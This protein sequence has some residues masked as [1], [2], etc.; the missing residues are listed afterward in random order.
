MKRNTVIKA[1]SALF[2]CLSGSGAAWA[3]AKGMQYISLEPLAEPAMLEKA[4]GSL[5]DDTKGKL[6]QGVKTVFIP[7]Y[8]VQFRV[9]S[10]GTFMKK[11]LLGSGEMSV[12]SLVRWSNPDPAVM[13]QVVDA[14]YADFVEQLKGAGFEVVPADKLVAMDEYKAIKP[15]AT[16]K[17]LNTAAVGSSIAKWMR[18]E[19]VVYSAAPL[20]WY[21]AGIAQDPSNMNNSYAENVKQDTLMWEKLGGKDSGNLAMLRPNLMV[22]FVMFDGKGWDTS[23]KEVD[24]WGR[25]VEITTS[26]ATISAIPMVSLYNSYYQVVPTYMHFGSLYSPTALGSVQLAAGMQ[27]G[28]ANTGF[29]TVTE[30]KDGDEFVFTADLAKYQQAAIDQLKIFNRLMVAKMQTYRK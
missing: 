3:A 5:T 28:S 12:Q 26:H 21:A 22:D 23:R 20:V 14:G 2:F 4:V 29:G 9:A 10:G 11:S 7:T 30:G 13:Q 24:T 19:S 6:L 8:P 25:R 18:S 1:L 16:G 27:L 17:V 15:L